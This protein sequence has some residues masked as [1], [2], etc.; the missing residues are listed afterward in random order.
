MCLD[1]CDHVLSEALSLFQR[2]L[3]KFLVIFTFNEEHEVSLLVLLYL[4]RVKSEAIRGEGS[5]GL[6][7]A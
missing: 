1:Y 7:V 5:N 2:V 6:K 3:A 4:E